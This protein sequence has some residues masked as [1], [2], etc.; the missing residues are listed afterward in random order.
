ML[1]HH[2]DHGR[3]GHIRLCKVSAT[4]SNDSLSRSSILFDPPAVVI[5]IDVCRLDAAK[6]DLKALLKASTAK[7]AFRTCFEVTSVEA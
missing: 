6:P 2:L 1:F 7:L 5:P 3:A 4:Y